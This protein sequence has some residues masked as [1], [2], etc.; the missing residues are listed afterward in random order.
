MENIPDGTF[1][2]TVEGFIKI[3]EDSGSPLQNASELM[4]ALQKI[5][6]ANDL[7]EI[8]KS[9]KFSKY[10]KWIPNSPEKIASYVAII[11]TLVQLWT[12]QPGHIEYNTFINQYNQTIEVQ[13][14]NKFT[15]TNNE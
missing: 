12:D 14:E 5:K 4:E 7:L 13:V 15:S 6:T 3:L 2:S 1:R 9:S 8:K 10:E 11:Y